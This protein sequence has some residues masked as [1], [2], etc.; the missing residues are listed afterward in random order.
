MARDRARRRRR[1]LIRACGR[2]GL[3]TSAIL[4]ASGSS[5]PDDLNG[6]GGEKNGSRFGAAAEDLS[7]GSDLGDGGPADGGSAARRRGGTRRGHQERKRS[8]T[9]LR[10]M[11]GLYWISTIW[12]PI[13]R[14]Q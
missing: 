14:T 9:M 1:S 2:V 10:N 12:G 6:S 8:D 4:T 3:Q 5:R 11:R 13:Y 7:S